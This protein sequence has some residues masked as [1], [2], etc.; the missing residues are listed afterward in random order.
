[1]SFDTTE[2][3]F[4]FWSRITFKLP[5][6]SS[7]EPIY[8]D[9]VIID[10][11]LYKDCFRGG[12]SYLHIIKTAS[13]GKLFVYYKDSIMGTERFVW[14]KDYNKGTEQFVLLLN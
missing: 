13:R 10:T 5:S 6:R 8:K 7:S 3:A 14:Y 11:V 9:C 12:S 4:W 1:M 2:F